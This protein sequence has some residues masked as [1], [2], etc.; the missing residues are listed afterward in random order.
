MTELDDWKCVAFLVLSLTTAGVAQVAWLRAGFSKRFNQ[1]LDMGLKLR[2]RALFGQNKT[3]RG[4]VVMVPASGLAFAAWSRLFAGLEGFWPLSAWE[5]FIFG[6]VAGFGFMAGEL[7]NSVLKRQ[8]DVAPGEAPKQL[9]LRRVCLL[10]DRTDSLLGSLLAMSLY[11]RVP[12][13]VWVGCLILGPG[14]HAV[15]SFALYRLGVKGRAG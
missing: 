10:L 6:C 5:F 3:L 14:I 13:S 9:W 8:L 12:W 4:F 1:R 15:F 11:Q 2:G 7:P